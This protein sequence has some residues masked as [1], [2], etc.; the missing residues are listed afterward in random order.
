M[1]IDR[2]VGHKHEEVTENMVYDLRSCQSDRFHK[3]ADCYKIPED[4]DVVEKP[5][6]RIESHRSPCRGKDCWG[7][8]EQAPENERHTCPY[9][10]EEGV[11]FARHL[12]C[13]GVDLSD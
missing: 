1:S 8:M 9:C 7:K 12:P 3:V 4:T 5:R 2:D 13:E 6:A 10:G 11:M